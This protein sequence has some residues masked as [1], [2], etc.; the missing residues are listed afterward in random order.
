M[1]VAKAFEPT[2]IY[3][4]DVHRIFWNKIPQDEMDIK[5][6]LLKGVLLKHI[7]K[8]I[9]NDDKI[10]LVGTSSQ[11]WSANVTFKKVFQNIL[12]IPESDYGS[13]F[14]MWLE[15]ITNNISD[16]YFE[17]YIFS[18]LAKVFQKYNTG[19]ISDNFTNCLGIKRRLRL[20]L[21]SIN[22]NEFLE[23]FMS[24]SF[25]VFSPDEKVRCTYLYCRVSY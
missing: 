13:I 9:K 2:I 20:H 19:D 17:D 15:L 4:K 6:T 14:L 21:N 5:P 18:V 23:D 1:K 11:P 8:F 25:P 10:M 24:R 22:P 12:L 7:L 3:I 16:Y